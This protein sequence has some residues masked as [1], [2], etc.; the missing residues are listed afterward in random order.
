M[1]SLTIYSRRNGFHQRSHLVLVGIMPL[2]SQILP[3]PGVVRALTARSVVYAVGSGVFQAGSALFF[4]RILGLSATQVGI[5]LSIAGAVTVLCSV[6]LGAVVDRFGARRTWIVAGLLEAAVFA[7][8]PLVGSFAAFLAVVSVL[9][10][11]DVTTSTAKHVYTLQALPPEER[12]RALAYQRSAL[13]VGFT[14]GAALSGVAVAVGTRSAYNVVVWGNAAV[15]LV[16]A[17]LIARMPR[18]AAVRSGPSRRFAA[19]ADRPFLA[20]SGINGVLQ[21]HTTLF[22][23]VL[24]LWMVTMTDAPKVLLPILY[25]VNTVMAVTLQVRA[26]RGSE[27]AYGSGLALKRSGVAVAVASLFLGAAA[28]TTGVPTIAVLVA[29]TML[30]TV[31]EL[32]Q[33]AGAWGITATLTPEDRRGE[34]TGTFKLGGQVQQTLAPAGL[35]VLAVS[36]HGWGWLAIAALM[37][38]AGAYAPRL[39]RRVAV[40]RAADSSPAQVANGAQPEPVAVR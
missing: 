37:L 4:T 30:L 6:P 31:G 23:I 5:G 13:N 19:L 10:L 38:A 9:A 22:A 12:V 17:V 3:P 39:V 18:V 35:T 24:P 40:N 36:T 2:I 14:A 27:T 11:A 8:Y 21:A 32:M 33:S 16:T 20:L 15:L 26:S 34:Y 25:T 1:I 29:G 7:A 28:L